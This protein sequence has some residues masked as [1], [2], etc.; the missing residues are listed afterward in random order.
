MG[1]SY[2]RDFSKEEGDTL[3]K[4]MRT[5]GFSMYHRSLEPAASYK[6]PETLMVPGLFCQ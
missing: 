1:W 4:F 5:V 2:F 6:Q 3:H